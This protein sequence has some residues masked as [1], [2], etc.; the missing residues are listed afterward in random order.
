MPISDYERF[1]QPSCPTCQ[2]LL[3][4]EYNLQIAPVMQE[5]F[6]TPIGEHVSDMKQFDDALKR[7]SEE[8]SG[9]MGFD[10]NYQPVDPKDGKHVGVTETE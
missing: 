2:Q 7:K 8:M 6:A 1:G 4:R 3:T 10:V 9:R 5:I